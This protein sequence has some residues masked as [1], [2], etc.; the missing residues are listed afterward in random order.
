MSP[1]VSYDL[2]GFQFITFPNENG[3]R[4]HVHVARGKNHNVNLKFWY[5]N[6][7]WVLDE[8]QSTLKVTP[9]ELRLIR[10][11]LARNRAQIVTAI[12]DF[13]NTNADGISRM[14]LE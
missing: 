3:E 2:M 4:F 10:E 1:K 7:E 12:V 14:R 5:V 8:S 13:H 6:S 9:R 11:H